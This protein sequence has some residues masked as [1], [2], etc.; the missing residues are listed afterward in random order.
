MHSKKFIPQKTRLQWGRAKRTRGQQVLRHTPIA[1]RG[2]KIAHLY[3]L[4]L[5]RWRQRVGFPW[6]K[7]ALVFTSVIGC[8]KR[9]RSRQRAY[10]HQLL[11][12]GED[13]LAFSR[14][15]NDLPCFARARESGIS[16]EARGYKCLYAGSV[17]LVLLR[18]VL[19]ITCILYIALPRRVRTFLFVGALA[20]RAL[21]GIW[22]MPR[23]GQAPPTPSSIAYCPNL[24]V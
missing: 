24:N 4:T 20:Q 9:S 14:S 10:L 12:W 21:W 8:R 2:G 3:P 7:F 16:A 17:L 6:E 13:L 15:Y 1:S 18:S 22:H 5:H 19:P 11:G 23:G